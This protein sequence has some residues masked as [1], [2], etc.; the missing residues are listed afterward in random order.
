VILDS[1]GAGAPFRVV[2]RHPK[3]SAQFNCLVTCEDESPGDDAFL[4]KGYTFYY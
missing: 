1:P 3:D 2:E 4:R